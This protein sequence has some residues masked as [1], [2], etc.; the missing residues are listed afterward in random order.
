MSQTYINNI[1]VQHWCTTTYLSKDIQNELIDCI[2]EKIVHCMLREIKQAKYYSI[3]LDCTPDLSHVGQLSV[4]V[5]MVAVDDT[6]TPQ[7]KEHFMGFLEVESST[8]ESLSN[9]ILKRLEEFNL[10]FEDC[11]GQSYDNG[12][13]MKG[14][15]K[16]VHARLLKKNPRALFVPCGAHTLN[17]VVAD[18][19]KS[20]TDALSLF[21][22]LQRIFTL[23]SASTQRWTTSKQQWNPGRIQDGKVELPVCRLWDSRQRRWGMPF[24]R[25]GRKPLTQWK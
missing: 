4:I 23:F 1:D 6:D 25:S 17:L 14:K 7:I 8:G 9:L 12:A 13:N 2:G 3:I 22:Y 18:A 21:G 20:S 11:R 10:P 19:A 5:R 24:L 16:G 15:I